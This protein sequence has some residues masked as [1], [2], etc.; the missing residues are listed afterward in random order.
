MSDTQ[1]RCPE[2]KGPLKTGD[3]T[4]SKPGP[5]RRA[6]RA[7]TRRVA[8]LT[9]EQLARKRTNDREAQRSTRQRTKNHIEELEQRIREL[10]ED[11]DARNYEQIKKRNADL[12]EELKQ[13]REALGRSQESAASSPELAPSSSRS[14]MDVWEGRHPQA[15]SPSWNSPTSINSPDGSFLSFQSSNAGELMSSFAPDHSELHTGFSDPGSTRSETLN[16]E[17]DLQDLTSAPILPVPVR[18]GGPIARPQFGRSRS[19]PHGRFGMPAS[20]MSMSRMAGTMT[21]IGSSPLTGQ[22]ISPMTGN[23]DSMHQ[24]TPPQINHS[25]IF[26]IK[27]GSM[28]SPMSPQQGSTKHNA[29][30]GVCFPKQPGPPIWELSLRFVPPTGPMDSILIGMLQGQRRLAHESTP[31]SVLIGPHQP[32]LRA[33]LNPEMSNKVHPVSSVISNLFYRV[34]YPTLAEKAAALVLVYHFCQWQIWPTME[35]YRKIPEWLRPR[36][37]QLAT[38][39]P[40][41]STLGRLLPY[42]NIRDRY[43]NLKIAG[44]G[45]APRFC[46]RQSGEVYNRRVL[47][48]V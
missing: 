35:T 12:E 23:A 33:L 3:P 9:P 45:K 28:D 15:Y 5:K 43:A 29:P 22:P 47:G 42:A 25:S 36:A 16:S 40:I 21:R 19:Y 14:G 34:L 30:I 38:P 31:G 39:H 2:S 41:W 7:E 17:S 46:G 18:R 26:N 20:N 44:M 10:S 1:P 32:D 37:L 4:S 48:S 27:Q 24:P 11:Q 8:S 6:S 13:L